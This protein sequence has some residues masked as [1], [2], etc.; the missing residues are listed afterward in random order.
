MI[1]AIWSWTWKPTR[2]RIACERRVRGEFTST[3]RRYAMREILVC[4]R[5]VAAVLCLKK[6]SSL[7]DEACGALVLFSSPAS[8]SV[9]FLWSKNFVSWLL[10]SP[11]GLWCVIFI[12]TSAAATK[13]TNTDK[14]LVRGKDIKKTWNA[15]TF[16]SEIIKL[17]W[18]IKVGAKYVAIRSSTVQQW[19]VVISRRHGR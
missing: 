17:I 15:I 10:K 12:K 4:E 5:L 9:T 14:F 2:S 6:L 16:S 13:T 18:T 8:A 3:V 19:L 1:S 11:F 7:R